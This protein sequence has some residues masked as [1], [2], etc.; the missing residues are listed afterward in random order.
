M[1]YQQIREYQIR[2]RAKNVAETPWLIL[3]GENK[4]TRRAIKLS[5]IKDH[6]DPEKFVG[7]HV[8]VLFQNRKNQTEPWP[9]KTINLAQVPKNFGFNFSLD[10]AQTVE[11]AQALQD[12]YSIGVDK[13]T[14]GKRT[15]LRGVGKD[16][17]IV[18]EKNKIAVLQ[19]LTKIL[20][21][22]EF[23]E[24]IGKNISALST[25]LALA[26]LYGDR[27][28]KLAT[29]RQA[30][31]DNKDENFWQAFLKENSW[32]FGTSYVEI[33]SERRLDIHHT[34]DFPLK[35]EGGFMDIVE[36]KKPQSPFWALLRNGAYYKYRDKYLI[37][38]QEL[39]GAI[40]QTT[41][42]ILQAEKK[43]DSAEY[44]K[45]HGGVVP[46]KPRGLI[47]HGRST[48]WQM[49]EWEAFRLLNDELH[50]VQVI[51]FDHLLRQAERMLLAMNVSDENPTL[52]EIQIDQIPPEDLPF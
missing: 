36:I 9:S 20:S 10:S 8:E 52:E 11:L 44:V 6:K 24:W 28:A 35:V 16:E 22:H 39:Q 5:F 46:L 19:Q 7:V 26:R 31:T 23:S 40:A 37:P 29:F 47:V 30:L 51:T 18:T 15:V 33:L 50:T 38:D 48:G 25:D 32:T 2:Q 1:D 41:K 12:A 4:L 14:S 17:I 13:I 27:R 3:P 21:E 34:S 43:L 45:D 42:Y 49:D